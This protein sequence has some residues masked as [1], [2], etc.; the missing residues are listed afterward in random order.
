[1]RRVSDRRR[2]WFGA[3]VQRTLDCRLYFADVERLADV[4][5]RSGAHRGDRRVERAEGANQ[6]DLCRW[7]VRF[8]GLENVEPRFGGIQVDIGNNQVET[9]VADAVERLPWSGGILEGPSRS[10]DQFGN[11]PAGLAIV[12]DNE[13]PLGGHAASAVDEG[14]VMRSTVPPVGGELAL[15]APPIRCTTSRAMLRPRPV[16]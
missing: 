7:L 9:L 15:I 3:P 6:Y 2:R 12:I 1:M 13:Y 10:A 5:E 14:S 4:V 11:Q 8:Y 16:P